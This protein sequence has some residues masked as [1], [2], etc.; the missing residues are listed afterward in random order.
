MEWIEGKPLNVHVE[1][2]LG[3]NHALQTLAQSWCALINDLR[4]NEIAHGD[5]QHGNVLI[6]HDSYKL[7][8]YDGM[9]VPALRVWEATKQDILRTSIRV[10][11]VTILGH[12][13][14]TLQP[15]PFMLRS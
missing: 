2:L 3:N 8:D 9:Y 14:I 7:I 4:K 11:A 15:W 12:I 10:V 13:S 1:S 5:L 6:V